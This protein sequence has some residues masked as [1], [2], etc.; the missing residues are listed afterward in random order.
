MDNWCT[1]ESDPGVFTE[2][3]Q[4][5]GVKGVEVEEVY[6]LNDQDYIESLKPIYGFI[7]LFKWTG[8]SSRRPPLFDYDP[9]LYFAKQVITNACATQALLSV[10]LNSKDKLTLSPDLEDL[11]SFGIS[12]DAYSRG[13]ILGESEQIRRVHNSF[14]RPEPFVQTGSRRAT[15]KDDV[16]HFVAYIHHNGRVYELDG[17]QEGPI[18]VADNIQENAWTNEALAEIQSRIQNYA[19]DEIKFNLLVLKASQESIIESKKIEKE[20]QILGLLD[21]AKSLNL[22]I[23]GI[24]VDVNTF[25]RNC[26]QVVPVSQEPNSILSDLAIL[27]QERE[28]LEWEMAAQRAKLKAQREENERRKQ[29]YLPLIFDLFKL[30]AETGHL[31]FLYNEA[32]KK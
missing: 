21:V 32:I 26:A 1:I 27:V 28:S 8:Q 6:A 4:D 17:L 20:S 18:V 29:N 12:L 11:R 25:S 13:L 7:F 22:N 9:E 5:L 15:E 19:A 2:L 16:F 3:I 24:P 14:A 10:L 31:E 30:A 23:S